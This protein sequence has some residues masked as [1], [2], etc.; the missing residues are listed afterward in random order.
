MKR[1]EV[2]SAGLKNLVFQVFPVISALVMVPVSIR[3][4]GAER[5]G[6]FS[7]GVTAV[8]MFNYMNFGVAVSVNRELARIDNDNE[9][10]ISRVFYSGWLLMLLIAILLSTVGL[11]L[12]SNIIEHVIHN[13]AQLYM[14]A[15]LL[16]VGVLLASPL[17]LTIILFRAALESRLRFG[18]TAS[19]RAFLNSVIFLSPGVASLLGKGIEFSF[20]IIVGVHLLSLAYLWLVLRKELP[21]KKITV[22]RHQLRKLF[23]S[24]LWMFVASG[25][26]L[27][28]F[29]SDRYIISV[30]IGIAAVAYYVAAYDL[31][32]RSSIIYGSISAPYAPAFARWYANDLLEEFSTALLSLYVVIGGVI[33]LICCVVILFTHEILYLWI[34]ADFAGKSAA[35]LQFLCFGIFLSAINAVPRV[36]YLA[37]NRER[38][39]GLI[40]I[41]NSVLFIGV[42]IF[43]IKMWGV[44]GAAGAF[45]V[46]SAAE[47]LLLHTFLGYGNKH[48]AISSEVIR[49]LVI[50]GLGLLILMTIL[51]FASSMAVYARVAM[52][53]MVLV[54]AT[55]L[56]KYGSFLEHF[57]VYFGPLIAKLAIPLRKARN[58]QAR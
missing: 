54:T 51:Y 40:C 8:V 36:L 58:Y 18:V 55:S 48:L 11:G 2:V 33:F 46:R 3:L 17:F 25:S 1:K 21:I 56:L 28:L 37:T 19:N 20:W 53:A 12:G 50:V 22:S 14:T 29:Y 52:L 4:Y 38:L 35:I 32:S 15:Y 57:S 23:G 5:F 27:L 41:V 7:L 31:I 6:L 26:S 45:V 42:L 10:E 24:G 43:F 39:L 30:M 34:N 47:F 44:R 13:N 16:I 9:M 49:K